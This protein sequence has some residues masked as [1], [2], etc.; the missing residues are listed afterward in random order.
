MKNLPENM[1]AIIFDLDGSLADSMWL[2]PEVDR[3]FLKKYQLT[4]PDHFEEQMEGMSYTET[5]RFFL[6][7]FPQLTLTEDELKQE[8]INMTLELYSTKVFLKKGAEQLLEYCRKNNIRLGIATSNTRKLVEAFL[9]SR[10]IAHLFQA[11]VTSCEVGKG[12]PEPDVYL[13]AARRLGVAPQSCLVFEDVVQGI[14]AAKR[15]GM[16]AWAVFD[17]ASVYSDK[18]KRE[19]ADEYIT[20]FTEIKL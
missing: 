19:L 13:E 10:N 8:W 5:A 2:W 3:I 4:A 17:A 16:K 7:T 18:Q 6:S 12:K 1:N 9:N 11:V 20:D 14:R 15:A